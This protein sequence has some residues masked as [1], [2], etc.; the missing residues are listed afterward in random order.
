ME[1]WGLGSGPPSGKVGVLA[2]PPLNPGYSWVVV[3][4]GSPALKCALVWI[5]KPLESQLS[6]SLEGQVS[7]QASCGYTT[8]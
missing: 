3:H 7:G 2:D 5:P 1:C 6:R 8:S 4:C